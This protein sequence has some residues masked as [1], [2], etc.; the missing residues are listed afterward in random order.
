M[1]LPKAI[2]TLG[3]SEAD[4]QRTPPAVRAAVLVVAQSHEALLRRVE[5]FEEKLRENSSNS[6]RPPSSDRPADR[7]KQKQKRKGRGKGRQPGGQPG[8]KGHQRTLLPVEQMKS[9][10][11]VKPPACQR[12]GAELSGED[13][14]PLR[15]QVTDVPP[16]QPEHHE[17]QLHELGCA[18]CGHRTR[19]KLPDDVPRGAFGPRVLALVALFT[20]AYRLSRRAAQQAMKDL[21]GV[22]MALGSVSN[23]EQT[24]SKAVEA[25]VAEAYDHVEEQPVAFVDET[26]WKQRAKSAFVWVASTAAVAVYQIVASRGRDAARKLL[27]AFRGV[28][29]TDRYVVYAGWDIKRRQLCWAHLLRCFQK[30]SERTGSARTIGEELLDCAEQLFYQWHRIRDGTIKWSTFRQNMYF[31]RLR[32]ERLLAQGAVCGHAKT[33]GT[34]RR[35]LDE[36]QALWTFTRIRGLQPTNNEAERALRKAVLWRKCSFGSWSEPGS[37][38]AAR[39]LTVTE[40]C[41]KQNRNVLDYLVSAV[42][43]HQRCTAFPSLRPAAP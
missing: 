43:A 33:E 23:G 38:Y 41:R 26:G 40:T 35:L 39:M 7:T 15:H 42:I 21:F 30:L 4:W 28:L 16:V 37:I 31:I 24:V 25:P 5:E 13:A 17:W 22:D 14:D 3:V 1:A 10:T 29:T 2:A 27:G 32:V 12:C 20:G 36:R 11:P 34:C 6:S 19:A 9:V 18:C 8:H